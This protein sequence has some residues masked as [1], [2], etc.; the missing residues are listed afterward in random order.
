MRTNID[1]EEK[2]LQRGLSLT[3]LPTKKALVNYAL[4][5]LVRRHD[6]QRILQLEGKITWTGELTSMRKNRG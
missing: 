3:K 6:V 1:L 2:L 4:L 5:E